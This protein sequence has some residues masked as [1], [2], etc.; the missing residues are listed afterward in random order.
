MIV[1]LYNPLCLFVNIS[2]LLE[3]TLLFVKQ[4]RELVHYF[5]V[6]GWKLRLEIMLWEIG[7]RDCS[8]VTCKGSFILDS[9]WKE[10]DLLL[11]IE[12]THIGWFIKLLGLVVLG[13]SAF[14]TH[15]C[16]ISE[17]LFVWF[18]GTLFHIVDRVYRSDKL[19]WSLVLILQEFFFWFFNVN[20]HH[21]L[22]LVLEISDR[23]IMVSIYRYLRYSRNLSKPL[24]L[25]WQF[26]INIWRGEMI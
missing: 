7:N 19:R 17:K 10:V 6:I 16:H 3:F 15:I 12:G 4:I 14:G 20:L 13:E 23:M 26:L 9:V 24:E 11:I 1:C 8:F 5:T 2:K 18:L 22:S 25:N 21:F